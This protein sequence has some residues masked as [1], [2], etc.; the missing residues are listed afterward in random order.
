MRVIVP[1]TLSNTEGSYARSGTATVI[2]SNGLVETVAANTIRS[3]YDPD[4]L[5][6]AGNLLEPQSQNLIQNSNEFAS[7]TNTLMSTTS[8]TGSTLSPDG[9]TSSDIITM[10]AGGG[11]INQ[12]TTTISG[13]YLTCSIHAKRN[14]CDYVYLNV[15]DQ[16]VCW[17]NLLTGAVG[18]NTSGGGTV[19]FYSKSIKK[20]G[21]EWYRCVLTVA[22]SGIT[23]ATVRFST[24]NTNGNTGIPGNSCY[25]YG[26]QAEPLSYATSYIPSTS[27]YPTRAADTFTGTTSSLYYS[28]VQ[29]ND[30]TPWNAATNYSVGDL[31]IRSTTHT[32][33]E[34]LIAG[35]NV[36]PPEDTV[37]AT[38][39]R[40]AE[41]SSTN[42][43]KLL[44]PY[45]STPTTVTNSL[46]FAVAPKIRIDSAALI[47]LT[48]TRYVGI[49]MIRQTT[50]EVVYNQVF[51]LNYRTTI[52]WYDYYFDPLA[53][54][55]GMVTFDLPPYTDGIL[56]VSLV[57]SNE[58]TC[59][60]CVFGMSKNLGITQRG[61][62]NDV[63]NFSTVNRDIFGNA[64]MVR[65]RN[66]PKT[67]QTVYADKSLLSQ[68][69]KVREDLNAVPALWCGLDNSQA[70]AY[71][72][73]LLILG[74]YRTFSINID[75]PIGVIINLELE[76]L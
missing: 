19:T 71:F 21:N 72:D 66:V 24:G 10:T 75:N 59:G 33:Y 74:F 18:T 70:D 50:G 30:Y 22:V 60:G 49:S 38:V 35:V 46:T 53:T 17:Y 76:E 20:Y 28:N 4:S 47:G 55:P 32:I 5:Q 31:V 61:A 43:W 52:G 58:I 26:F 23:T 25:V 29:E 27:S 69:I 48:G 36:T 11:T 65:R 62:T 15:N 57:G 12:L 68:I 63:L 54:A 44:D 42:R 8:N 16:V 67:N 51:D 2:N 3:T 41:V 14:N 1:T 64:E 13:N 39:P 73:A 56:V 37:D 34:C 7:W 9:T 6:F 40:W 45:R